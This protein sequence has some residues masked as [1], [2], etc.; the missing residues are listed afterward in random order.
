MLATIDGYYAAMGL[1]YNKTAD[2][3]WCTPTNLDAARGADWS[4]VAPTD[5]YVHGSL[6]DQRW[7]GH[8]ENGAC[9]M[10]MTGLEIMA[11]G[12]A[13][14]P[15]GALT[16]AKRAMRHFNTTRFWGQ[17]YDWCSGDHCDGPAPGFNGADVIA[18]S[19]MLL[20]GA[21]HSMFGFS[22]NISGVFT[23]GS[24][25][26]ELKE[27]ATHSFIHLGERVTL[28]ISGGKTLISH[29]QGGGA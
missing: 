2:D 23:F 26:K 15:D 22:T 27:G 29:K 17:H 9:F 25:A 14:D 7:F 5:T 13:G 10:V 28:T 6:Q 19:V 11:R 20:H 8:Y 24:P 16:L 18:N 21:V 4:G 3:L 12:Q 1:R